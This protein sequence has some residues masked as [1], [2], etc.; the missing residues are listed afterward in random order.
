MVASQEKV[1]NGVSPH[2]FPS[3][4]I[5]N[6]TFYSISNSLG[7]ITNQNSRTEKGTKEDKGSHPKC[8]GHHGS[9]ALILFL[10]QVPGP[11]GDEGSQDM[12]EGPGALRDSFWVREIIAEKGQLSGL[13][14]DTWSLISHSGVL[15]ICGCEAGPSWQKQ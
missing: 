13:G 6:T 11:R 10:P 1:K 5:A 8:G 4:N 2:S 9:L 14:G 3:S 7:T 12:T 15:K